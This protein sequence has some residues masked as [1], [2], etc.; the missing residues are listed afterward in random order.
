MSISRYNP[1]KKSVILTDDLS[2]R[3]A[4]KFEKKNKRKLA[5]KNRPLTKGR[6]TIDAAATVLGL[7]P[8]SFADVRANSYDMF[9]AKQ[10]YSVC[11]NRR[12]H[13][14][15]DSSPLF[16][17]KPLQTFPF[18]RI[19]TFAVIWLGIKGRA[20]GTVT[21][22]IIDRSY[23]DPER[24][25]EVEI[26]YPMAKTFAVLGSLPNFM[27]YEDADKMQV[28]IV[29]KDDSVQNC[30][31]SRSLWFWGIERT[32]FPVPMESQK[33]VMFEFEPLPDRTVNHLSKFKNFTTDVVQ[34]AVT[35]AFT[36][37]EALEDKPGIEFGV[38]KQPGVPLVQKK[39][40]MIEA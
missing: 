1:F 40:V 10:D 35:T 31:I 23:T 12:T 16:F 38:V 24:Q 6:M 30:I 13:F 32:D 9:V 37:R 11:A 26:C 33:T 27:S 2:E 21:F 5:L 29:I 39:R 17:R 20:N 22:R 28:E 4:E 3:A 36:T 8:F 14:T 34:R 18:F 19:A 25:V 7:E 15:I